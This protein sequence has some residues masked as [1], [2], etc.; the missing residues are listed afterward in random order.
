MRFGYGDISQ[1]AADATRSLSQLPLA[2]AEALFVYSCAGRSNY[3]KDNIT[4]E[5]APLAATPAAV[6]FFSYGEFFHCDGHNHLLNHTLTCLLLAEEGTLL[7]LVSGVGERASSEDPSRQA[8]FHLV[9]VTF[10]LAS[11]DADSEQGSRSLL[12]RADI[13]LRQALDQHRELVVYSPELPMVRDLDRNLIWLRRLRA[14]LREQRITAYFQPIY[15]AGNGQLA[16]FEA[17]I[18]LID[19][20]EGKAVSPYLFLDVA[21]KSRLYHHLTACVLHESLALIR[22]RQVGVSINL[23]LLDLKHGPTLDLIDRVIAEPAIGSR[24][25]FEIVESEGFE[26]YS[27]V[28]DF[29]QRVKAFGCSVVIDNFGSGYS[30]FAHFARRL[31]IGTTAEFVH[32]A[33]VMLLAREMGI[34]H[35]QGFHLSPPVTFDQA[36]GLANCRYQDA[37]MGAG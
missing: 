11:G 2:K 36:L 30:S 6:G 4:T 10:D 27:L 15:S 19:D 34:T 13:A 5:L 37:T 32:N 14:A 8:L 26:D 31:G 16:K 3:L 1:I 12:L 28:S 20:D 24:L 7:P 23:S 33:E 18:R 9:Q 25:T 29:I 17:L 22:A 35:L 21:K